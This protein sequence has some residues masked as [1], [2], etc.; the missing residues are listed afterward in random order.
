MKLFEYEKWFFDVYTSTNAYFIVFITKIDV[1]GTTKLYLQ[2]HGS[3]EQGSGTYRKIFNYEIKLDLLEYSSDG[4]LA[5]QGSI[6]FSPDKIKL[7]L[8]N[9]DFSIDLTYN[10][11]YSSFSQQSEMIIHGRRKAFMS[12]KPIFP[13]ARVNGS[14]EAGGDFIHHFENE[15][16]Y[17]D[18]VHSTFLPFRIPV[19]SMYWGRLH[20]PKADLTYSI[21]QGSTGKKQWGKVY[22]RHGG[23]WFEFDVDKVECMEYSH[24][25]ELKMY[26][27][28]IYSIVAKNSEANLEITVYNHREMILNDFMGDATYMGQLALQILRKVTKN[29]RGIKFIATADVKMHS[30]GSVLEYFSLPIIDE[31]NIF[32]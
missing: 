21:V 5:R 19:E 31:Y 2:M 14:V 13:R 4:I 26:Y 9:R 1:A 7:S 23:Q 3:N 28:D 24:C 12:W 20:A 16:G 27:P 6:G 30:P 25:K 11:P 8:T 18:Y 17:S 22:F 32:G 15:T 10:L 29:P